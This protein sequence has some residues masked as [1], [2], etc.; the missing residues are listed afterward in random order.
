MLISE[1]LEGKAYYSRTRKGLSGVIQSAEKRDNVFTSHD[2]YAYSV[3]VR[4]YWN[5]TGLPKP[6]FYATVYVS[7]GE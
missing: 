7:V 1:I 2:E 5:G 4:P 3:K 6:D